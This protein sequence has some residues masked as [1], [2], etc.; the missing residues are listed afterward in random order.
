MKMRRWILFGLWI[1][2]LVGISFYGGAVSYGFFFGVTLLPVVSLVY[3]LCIFFRFKIYQEIESRNIVCGQPVSYYFVLQNEDYFGFTGVSVN[4]YSLFSY[5]EELPDNIEYELLPGDK[6]THKTKLVC[7]YRGEYE[8]GVKAVVITDFFRLF[9]LRYRVSSPIKAVVLP[10]VVQ[11]Q[12]LAGIADSPM[13]TH[14]EVAVG[15]EPD[16]LVRDYVEGDSLK[17]IHWKATAREQKLKVRTRKGEEKQGVSIFCD[18]GRYSRNMEEYLPIENK[19]LETL[20]ALGYFFARQ[21]MEFCVHYR[22]NSMVREYVRG[23]QDFNEFYDR[24]SEMSFSME[25]RTKE[26]FAYL[27]EEGVL[28]G[29][30]AVF[31]VLHEISN[32]IMEGTRRLAESGTIVVI[33]VITNQNQEEYV[34]QGSE[35]RKVIVIPIEAELEGIM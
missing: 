2:S 22:Q 12:E 21:D 6:F 15:M 25:E 10:K 28:W 1:L 20:L 11:L 5:V 27:L 19:I 3:L 18:T 24:M 35:R 23:I 7:R 31:C 30:K 8:V 17:Q 14:K 16:I 32:E 26:T 33:Y 34:R 13:L 4:M 29:S 9:R